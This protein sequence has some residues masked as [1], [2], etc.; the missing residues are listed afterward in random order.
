MY[1]E[2]LFVRFRVILIMLKQFVIWFKF[3]I[4]HHHIVISLLSFHKNNIFLWILKMYST[5]I[6]ILGLYKI[7]N[8][9]T[10]VFVLTFYSN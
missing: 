2:F 3:L 5:K 10:N 4:W 7:G 9:L 6:E 1:M 8:S